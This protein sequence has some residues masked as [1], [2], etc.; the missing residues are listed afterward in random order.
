MVLHM[1]LAN[2]PY[3]GK[4]ATGKPNTQTAVTVTALHLGGNTMSMLNVHVGEKSFRTHTLDRVAR[5][6]Y[7]SKAVAI[8]SA[9]KPDQMIGVFATPDRKNFG[10]L[11]VRDHFLV[12]KPEES[13]PLTPGQ[14]VPSKA[15]RSSYK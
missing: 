1:H 6:L 12:D 4:L 15:V 2:S 8:I 13:H 10:V 9:E 5:R 3:P 11:R 14:P 7:G